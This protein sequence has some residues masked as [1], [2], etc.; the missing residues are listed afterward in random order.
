MVDIQEQIL[1]SDE[2]LVAV[3]KPAGLLSIVDGYIANLPHLAG[4]LQARYGRVWTVHRLDKDTSGVIIFAL[5]AD[6]HRSLSEQFQKRQIQK[7]YHAIIV[8]YPEFETMNIDLPLLVDGDRNH[9]TIIDHQTG[10]PAETTV[11]V[12]DQAAG[13]ALLAAFPHS[14]YTHQIRAHLAAIGLPIL[15]DPLYKSLKPQTALQAKAKETAALLP[16][17]RL[18]LHARTL[19]IA[20]PISGV[21]LHFDAP[22]PAD[23][24]QA[25]Q[26][27]F[28][29]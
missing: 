19:K 23:F 17:Q 21:D 5:T 13:F 2:S 26:E 8:G 1:W 16:I 9:R 15:F 20:H 14:G 18:A 12:F 29:Q 24:S 22:Y 28:E 4:L 10:K 7:E 25:V 6:A 27:L 11:T 3:N